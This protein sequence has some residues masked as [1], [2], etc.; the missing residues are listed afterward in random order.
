MVHKRIT[1]RTTK[2]FIT[3]NC[4]YVH[5][6]FVFVTMK[7]TLR[8][9]IHKWQSIGASETVL[10]WL[11]EGVKFT[12]SEDICAF[13]IKNVEFLPDKSLTILFFGI[14][15]DTS[16]SGFEVNIPQ[17]SNNHYIDPVSCLQCYI[18]RTRSVRP[19][20]TKPVFLSLIAPFSPI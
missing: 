5:L 13:E 3:L 4:I 11:E 16:Q 10:Q 17:N 15:N 7:N 12:L 14:K 19:S 20:D 8:S 1:K 6:C 9:N 2:C 18:H